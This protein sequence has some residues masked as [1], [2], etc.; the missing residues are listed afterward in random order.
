MDRFLYRITL[1]KWGIPVL[2]TGVLFSKSVVV[3]F[4]LYGLEWRVLTYGILTIAP[5][6][7]VASFAL[8]FVGWGRWKYFL[9]VNLFLTIVFIADLTYSR[10]LN[11]LFSLYV[12]FIKNLNFNFG[13][14]TSRYFSFLDYMMLLDIPI[15]YL[16]MRRVRYMKERKEIFRRMIPR[17]NRVAV[18]STALMLSLVLMVTQISAANRSQEMENFEN[19]PLLLSPL[20]NHMVNLATFVSEQFS[21]TLREEELERIEAWYAANAPFLEAAPEHASLFGLLEGMNLVFIHYESL[22]SFVVGETLMGHEI[23]PTV[24]R[25]LENSIAFTNIRE[26]IREG[27]S[28]DTELMLNTGLYPALKGSAFMSYGENAFFALPEL[29][30]GDGYRTMVVH[31]DVARFW[32]RD[33]VYPNLGIDDYIHEEYFEDRRMSGL[34]IL[35]E[36]LF[37]QSMKELERV[38]SP[39]YA[40]LMSVTSH[41]PFNLEEEH[42]YLGIPYDPEDEGADAGYLESIHYMDHHLGV[43]YREMEEKG[44]LENTAFVVFGDHEGLNKYFDTDLPDNEKKLPFF[45]HIPGMEAMEVD[46]LGGQIDMLPTL[47]YLLGVET[48]E[49]AHAVMGG[50]LLGSH[51]GSVLMATGEV[52]GDPSRGDH[53]REAMAVAQLILRGDYFLEEDTKEEPQAPLPQEYNLGDSDRYPGFLR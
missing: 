20:G 44:M 48:E 35:D 16:V 19:H 42:R 12:L 4:S 41:T 34:G 36:S 31:G 8:L 10:G 15:W 21:T 37:Q 23:T 51:P 43:F 14:S 7:L 22:E 32:N 9:L 1:S 11:Q 39:Y 13:V 3:L 50:N 38:E 49:Y 53:L 25:M 26:Q 45:I 28:S 6:L 40:Y 47:L 5:I 30:R 17:R 33:V 52:L 2:M 29:L 46:T 18:F 24:N 27:T